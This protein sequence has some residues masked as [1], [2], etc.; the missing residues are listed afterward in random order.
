[1]VAASAQI[2]RLYEL[3][4]LYHNTPPTID[5]TMERLTAHFLIS[6]FE[7]SDFSLCVSINVMARLERCLENSVFFLKYADELDP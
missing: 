3:F 7:I 5:K 2:Q 6:F 4:P 1:M